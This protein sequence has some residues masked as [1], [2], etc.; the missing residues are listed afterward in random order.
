MLQTRMFEIFTHKLAN[1]DEAKTGMG[2][3][4][5]LSSLTMNC[6]DVNEIFDIVLAQPMPKMPELKISVY[7]PKAS[8][9][10]TCSCNPKK[11]PTLNP[12]L[13][14][15]PKISILNDIAQALRKTKA[16]QLHLLQAHALMQSYYYSHRIED[17]N[18]AL[19]AC[20]IAMELDS[21]SVPRRYISSLLELFTD[22]DLK[23][24][25]PLQYLNQA[26]SLKTNQV[27]HEKN[28]RTST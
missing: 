14:K 20:V 24:I 27:H 5:E 19:C 18:G 23:K 6:L 3:F 12:V 2:L 21:N 4:M 9:L 26:N 1:P 10:A 28:Y 11:F 17:V 13:F 22:E 16:P 7:N 15:K 25:L 8:T